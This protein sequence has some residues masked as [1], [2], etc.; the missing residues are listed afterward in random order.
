M[1]R[2]TA[3]SK[4]YGIL[5]S[6]SNFIR[7]E[8]R[9]HRGGALTASYPHSPDEWWLF[10]SRWK[11]LAASECGQ[12]K[13]E[14]DK[15]RQILVA[16]NSSSSVGAFQAPL[17]GVSKNTWRTGAE[18]SDP[19]IHGGR[20]HGTWFG[21]YIRTHRCVWRP[22]DMAHR[23]LLCTSLFLNCS[24]MGDKVCLKLL[25]QEKVCGN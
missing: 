19:V 5:P 8:Q 23:F 20:A 18:N 4:G 22:T 16:S 3:V 17:V 10:P 15:G 13:L 24:L 25:I 14:W 12:K 7:W 2:T 1:W 6:R 11:D 9:G 21:G